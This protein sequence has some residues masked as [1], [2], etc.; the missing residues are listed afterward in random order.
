MGARRN[1]ITFFEP[2]NSPQ[3]PWLK[4]LQCAYGSGGDLN[5]VIADAQ[6]VMKA[7]ASRS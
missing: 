2:I 3:S 1:T 5:T 4:M 7:I 6:T